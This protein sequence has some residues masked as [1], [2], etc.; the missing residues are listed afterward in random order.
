MRAL[1]IG[2]TTS[3]VAVLGFAGSANADATVDLLWGGVSSAITGPDGSS[4]T[5]VLAVVITAGASGVESFGLTVDYSSAAGKLAVIGYTNS[6]NL[7]GGVPIFPLTL[8]L[9]ADTGTSVTNIN[10]GSLPV[11]FLGTGLFAGQSFLA[12]TITFHKAAGVG[13]FSLT[14]GILPASTDD[15][16]GFGGGVISATTTFNG[17]SITNIPEPGTV[18]LLGLGLGALAVAGRRRK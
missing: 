14:P 5:L 2:I 12:G 16:I 4:T 17:A 6:A 13:T 18:S 9:T 11:A 7:G 10:A 15:I 8:G 3:L 1:L